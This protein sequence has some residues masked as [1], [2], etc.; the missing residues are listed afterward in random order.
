MSSKLHTN[1][2]MKS[3]DKSSIE[4]DKRIEKV[5]FIR[6]HLNN[7]V[8]KSGDDICDLP[9]TQLPDID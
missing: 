2:P 9:S 4:D 5:V 1:H 3:A 8:G 6:N 7:E